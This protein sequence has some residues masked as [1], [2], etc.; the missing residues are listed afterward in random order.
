[1][2]R[3]LGALPPQ[4]LRKFRGRTHTWTCSSEQ[5][6]AVTNDRWRSEYEHPRAKETSERSSSLGG[7]SWRSCFLGPPRAVSS[8]KWGPALQQMIS[9]KGRCAH[10]F[11]NLILMDFASLKTRI[12]PPVPDLCQFEISRIGQRN[13]ES[14]R[15]KY[16]STSRWQIQSQV[17]RKTIQRTKAMMLV[18]PEMH[19]QLQISVQMQAQIY[20]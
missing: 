15:E 16:I 13:T 9:M 11:G 14:A 3:F 1:M 19:R 2:S 6:W 8:I 4:P 12:E 20:E 10:G 17:V 18:W 7:G 5:V